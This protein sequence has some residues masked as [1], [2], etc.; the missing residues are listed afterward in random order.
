MLKL[1]ASIE[2]K[3]E[4]HLSDWTLIY[5]V[6]PLICKIQNSKIQIC[7]L[8]A[9][10]TY[11]L[12]CRGSKVLVARNIHGSNYCMVTNVKG[13]TWVKI[14][15]QICANPH[16]F[17]ALANHRSYRSTTLSHCL[18]ALKKTSKCQLVLLYATPKFA[19]DL[20]SLYNYILKQTWNSCLPWLPLLFTSIVQLLFGGWATFIQSFSN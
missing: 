20:F 4:P 9:L 13:R 18:V 10:V 2:A 11:A 16:L 7:S 8:V 12:V 6:Q 15:I 19:H 17:V 1:S 3:V 14:K 5:K